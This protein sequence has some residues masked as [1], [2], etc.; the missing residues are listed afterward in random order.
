M[1]TAH[2]PVRV[3]G[4]SGSLQHVQPGPSSINTAQPQ[5]PVFSSPMASSQVFVQNQDSQYVHTS[6]MAGSAM[7]QIPMDSQFSAHDGSYI[8]H[9]FIGTK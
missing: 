3:N 7:D 2:P 9:N 1:Q 5:Q 6:Y 8:G 4:M